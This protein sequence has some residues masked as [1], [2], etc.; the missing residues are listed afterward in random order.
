MPLFY[1]PVKRRF[2]GSAFDGEGA[3]RTGGRWSSKRVAVLYAS[4]SVALAVLEALV[5]LRSQDGVAAS[6]SLALSLP[7]VLVPHRRI[8]L[9][10]PAH[11]AF[12]A[13][14]ESVRIEPLHA[15]SR[16]AARAVPVPM[17]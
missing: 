1:R 14:V 8:L 13:V 15:D 10:N 11:K 17:A 7:S 12:R 6:S 5:H 3:K 16:V 2:S 9:I 4:D